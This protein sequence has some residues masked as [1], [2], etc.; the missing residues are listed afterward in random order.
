MNGMIMENTKVLSLVASSALATVRALQSSK[1]ATADMATALGTKPTYDQWV[2]CFDQW[3]ESFK[4]EFKKTYKT[5]PAEKTILNNQSKLVA[6]LNAEYSLSKPQKPTASAKAKAE[7]RAKGKTEMQKLA[8]KP[9]AE[10]QAEKTALCQKAVQGDIE[11]VKAV[12]K[13]AKVI[14]QK[15]KADSKAV[16]SSLKVTRD[17]LIARIKAE[18]NLEMLN[19]IDALLDS[20]AKGND[21]PMV[22]AEPVKA[23]KVVNG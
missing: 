21:K 22:T 13:L 9:L 6:S 5:E 4:A 19:R 3:A 8:E 2:F 17:K 1:T 10:L 23:K 16:T 14:E 11:A 20:I 7:Q 15:Q 18:C 12:T